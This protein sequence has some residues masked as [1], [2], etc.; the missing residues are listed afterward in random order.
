MNDDTE[1][2]ASMVQEGMRDYETRIVDRDTKWK[3]QLRRAV[4][5]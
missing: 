1:L 3:A 5:K 2:D 4:A